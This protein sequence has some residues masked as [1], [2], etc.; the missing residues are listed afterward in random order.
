MREVELEM[1]ESQCLE[2]DLILRRDLMGRRRR[3]SVKRPSLSAIAEAD[4][5][6]NVKIVEVDAGFWFSLIL[7]LI[8]FEGNMAVRVYVAKNYSCFGFSLEYKLWHLIYIQTHRHMLLLYIE[9]IAVCATC[10]ESIV[11]QASG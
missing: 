4:G 5:V 9:K 2:R 3:I 10:L 11:N 1:R 7:I 8:R 6:E